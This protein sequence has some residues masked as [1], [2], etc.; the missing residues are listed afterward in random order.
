[1]EK[2]FGGN[3]DYA[4]LQKIYSHAGKG[5][6]VHQ[7]AAHRYGPGDCIGTKR[8]RLIGNPARKD[9]ST[10]LVE[11]SNLTMRMSNRRFTRLTNS[12]SKKLENHMHAISLQ[13]MSYNFCKIHNS[14][15]VTPAMEAG[16]T[17]H[18]WSMEE[19][20]EMAETNV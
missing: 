12:F 1:V 13:F 15:R 14:L 5:G 4:M 6:R 9:I 16:V 19:V 10:S 3:I 20:V 17:D 7:D 8:R 11:R 2:S 18:V